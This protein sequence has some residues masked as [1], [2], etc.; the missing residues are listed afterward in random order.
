M[1]CVLTRVAQ[2]FAGT[3]KPKYKARVVNV[4]D[5]LLDESAAD[6]LTEENAAARWV[7]APKGLWPAPEWVAGWI[8]QIKSVNKAT[9]YTEIQFP[10]GKAGMK[11]QDVVEQ[12]KVI[13]PML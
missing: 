9:K 5:P 6:A 12:L 10:D 2:A 11:F 8:G 1:R 3:L 4:G 7:L 13:S